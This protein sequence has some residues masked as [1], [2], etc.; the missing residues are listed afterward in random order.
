VTD[1]EL[2][3]VI[4]NVVRKMTW[5]YAGDH[6]ETMSEAYFIAAKALKAF[7]G[8]GSEESYVGYRIRLG[9]LKTFERRRDMGKHHTRWSIHDRQIVANDPQTWIARLL[10]DLSEDAATVLRAAIDAPGEVA[11]C[12]LGSGWSGSRLVAAIDEIVE[13]V[14]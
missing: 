5:V 12:L 6:E 1:A 10:T 2:H 4:C 3:K 9:L 8:R 11:E 7:D 13:A 14:R